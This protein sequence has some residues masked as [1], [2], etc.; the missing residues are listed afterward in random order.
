V[1]TAPPAAPGPPAASV[2][3][4]VPAATTVP[5]PTTAGAA[6][7][8]R[9]GAEIEERGRTTI[10]DK[11]VERVAAQAVE[12]VDRATGTPRRFLGTAFGKVKPESRARTSA[13]VD[14]SIVTVSV[15]MSVEWPAPVREVAA[16]VRRQVRLRVAEVCGLEVV[17]V[18]VDVPTFLTTKPTG[19]RV[20]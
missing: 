13:K 11:V 12:E 9:H 2:P 8:A 4:T 20:R 1:V 10:A 3:A 6:L 18:D 17:E 16:Q 14:G 5:A 7:A 15:S 19:P